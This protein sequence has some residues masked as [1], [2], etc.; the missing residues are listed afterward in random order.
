MFEISRWLQKHTKTIIT[1]EYQTSWPN[2]GW[3]TKSCNISIMHMQVPSGTNMCVGKVRWFFYRP[4]YNPCGSLTWCTED[5]RGWP[6]PGED[7]PTI[8]S[9]FHQSQS[10]QTRTSS[11][12][13]PHLCCLNHHSFW[14]VVEPPLW[15]MMDFVSW[16]DDI[17][18][19]WK[20]IKAMFQST[21]QIT[22]IFPLLLVYSL[23]TTINHHYEPLNDWCLMLFDW[24]LI[25]FLYHH[26]WELQRAWHVSGASSPLWAGL[27]KR[28]PIFWTTVP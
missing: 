5:R 22:I 3:F 28:C 20:V 27:A 23:L 12:F 2:W 9:M 8:G 24:F 1:Q 25:C 26:H 4:S 17:P 14:L 11:S 10:L 21:N 16:D 6:V 19:T 18:N 13:D 7:H 15:K